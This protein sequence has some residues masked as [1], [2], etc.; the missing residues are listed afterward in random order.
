[1]T[2]EMTHEEYEA[3]M[4]RISEIMDYDPDPS[5]ESATGKELIRLASLAVAYERNYLDDLG[6]EA[7]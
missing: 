3:V 7:K 5:L 4:A 6:W 1:M 2:T